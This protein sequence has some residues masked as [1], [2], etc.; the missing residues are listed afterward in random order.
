MNAT[1]VERTT[2]LETEPPGQLGP[3]PGKYSQVQAPISKAT[4][5]QAETQLAK[6]QKAINSPKQLLANPAH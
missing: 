5:D 2:P 1:A 3:M 4:R 6:A